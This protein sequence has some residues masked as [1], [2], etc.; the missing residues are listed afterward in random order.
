MLTINKPIHS[1]LCFIPFLTI[2]FILCYLKPANG[3]QTNEQIY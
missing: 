3:V 1:Y 2:Y